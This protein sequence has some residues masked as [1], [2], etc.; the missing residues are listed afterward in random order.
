MD[1]WIEEAEVPLLLAHISRAAHVEILELTDIGSL[2]GSNMPEA[3]DRDD[4]PN[5]FT[6][7]DRNVKRRRVEI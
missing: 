4:E 7:N 3:N 5:K 1:R 6:I 2:L